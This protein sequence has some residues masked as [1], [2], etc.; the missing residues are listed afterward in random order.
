M[1]DRISGGYIIAPF[2][3]LVISYLLGPRPSAAQAIALADWCQAKAPEDPPLRTAWTKLR[4]LGQR[5]AMYPTF[6]AAAIF[7]AASLA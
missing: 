5:Y 3:S 7:L 6:G 2:A 4:K 1:S